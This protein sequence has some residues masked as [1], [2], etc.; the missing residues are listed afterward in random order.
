MTEITAVHDSH[1]NQVVVEFVV[2]KDY[3][4]I[5]ISSETCEHWSRIFA[6]LLYKTCSFEEDDIDDYTDSMGG[7]VFL[8]KIK[9]FNL[10]SFVFNISESQDELADL[11]IYYLRKS[12]D[13][14]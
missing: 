3:N 11:V 14:S 7:E 13:N 6:P 5:E 1:N 9:Q 12:K 2:H 4:T 8:T 10:E